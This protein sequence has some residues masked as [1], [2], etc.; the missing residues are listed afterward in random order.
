MIV[1][2]IQLSCL[3]YRTTTR[4]QQEK[5]RKQKKKI[6]RKETK[7][8]Q[9]DKPDSRWSLLKRQQ[10]FSCF[11]NISST[12]KKII[13]IINPGYSMQIAEW[14]LE[15]SAFE[16]YKQQKHRGYMII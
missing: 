16:Y 13:I 5:E 14:T 4:T 6:N 10:F 2:I 12:L 15:Y 1:E 3:N 11:A 9:T 7:H 8:T